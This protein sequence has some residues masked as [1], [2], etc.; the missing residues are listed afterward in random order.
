[1]YTFYLVYIQGTKSAKIFSHLNAFPEAQRSAVLFMVRDIDEN[2]ALEII[3]S[4]Q[5]LH[6]IWLMQCF[7]DYF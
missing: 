7:C 3:K 4:V 2:R 6:N 1:M 5:E